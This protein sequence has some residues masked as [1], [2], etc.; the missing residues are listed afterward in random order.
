LALEKALELWCS[1][2]RGKDVNWSHIADLLTQKANEC[3]RRS[4]EEAMG[5]S[6][7][8]D[9][10][11]WL[12]ASKIVQ[13]WYRLPKFLDETGAPRALKLWGADDSVEALAR[14]RFASSKMVEAAIKTLVDVG[15]CKR[16]GRGRY[17]PSQYTLMMACRPD[18]MESRGSMILGC[19]A[20]TFE[21]NMREENP[22]DREFERTINSQRLRASELPA[23]RHFLSAQG[24]E[25]IATIDQWLEQRQADLGEA[26]VEINIELFS[27]A[28]DLH[29]HVGRRKTD[30]PG[31]RQSKSGDRLRAGSPVYLAEL[32]DADAGRPQ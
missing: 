19:L 31:R 26:S 6:L 12:A 20:E 30:Q 27:H 17:T 14:T 1:A 29:G 10:S 7:P 4:S 25:F 18:M 3:R 15:G 2:M 9:A 23:F 28:A 22:A 13:D 8:T 16:T 5:A 11:R 24:A 21:H 32:Q